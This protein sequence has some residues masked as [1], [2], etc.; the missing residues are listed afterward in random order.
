MK[1][2]KDGYQNNRV[3]ADVSIIDVGNRL[4]SGTRA[5]LTGN[6]EHPGFRSGGSASAIS[7]AIP[8]RHGSYSG[9]TVAQDRFEFSSSVHNVGFCAAWI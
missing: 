7:Q 1:I 8:V 2:L 4:L 9:L 3:P 6:E 5:Q